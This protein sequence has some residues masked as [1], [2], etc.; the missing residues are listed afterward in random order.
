L[1]LENRGVGS[2]LVCVRGGGLWSF[3]PVYTTC[4]SSVLKNP[5]KAHKKAHRKHT[6]VFISDTLQ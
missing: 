1:G 5:P 6:Y 2:L 4:S 3:S